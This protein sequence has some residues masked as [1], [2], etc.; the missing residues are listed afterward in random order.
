MSWNEGY[1]Y[2]FVGKKCD[3]V[4]WGKK[5]VS[6]EMC[7]LDMFRWMWCLSPTLQGYKNLH[8]SYVVLKMKKSST[9]S[10]P[11]VSKK[12]KAKWQDIEI[13][14]KIWCLCVMGK[15]V[16]KI[17]KNLVNCMLF[18]DGVLDDNCISSTCGF[19]TPSDCC[20]FDVLEKLTQKKVAL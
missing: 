8:V 4:E 11:C 10:K 14:F 6:G 5:M 3:S 9:L 12:N 7:N 17:P 1:T 19:V 18:L 20:H 15:H 16:P 2:K 13:E